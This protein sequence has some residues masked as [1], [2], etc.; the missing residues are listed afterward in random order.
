MKLTKLTKHMEFY[1]LEEDYEEIEQGFKA[2]KT[3]FREFLDAHEDFVGEENS[4]EHEQYLK[5]VESKYCSTVEAVKRVLKDRETELREAKLEEERIKKEAEAKDMS[6]GAEKEDTPSQVSEITRVL[7]YMQMPQRDLQTFDGDPM[8]YYPFISAFEAL[9]EREDID[10]RDKLLCLLHRCKGKALRAIQAFSMVENGYSKARAVLEERFGSTYRI[11]DTWLQHITDGPR[12]GASDH[13]GLRDFADDLR[14]CVETLAS[15]GA[16]AELNTLRVLRQITD[17]LPLFLRNRWRTHVQK[18]RR[19]VGQLG[20]PGIDELLDFVEDAAEEM[21][22][23]VYG[24]TATPKAK[25]GKFESFAVVNSTN[26]IACSGSCKNLFVCKAFKAMLVSDRYHFVREHRLC[27][28]CLSPDHMVSHCTSQKACSCG[29]KHVQLLHRGQF[30]RTKAQ[31]QSQA[32]VHA[33]PAQPPAA[34]QNADRGHEGASSGF[35]HVTSDRSTATLPVAMVQVRANGKVKT[36]NALLDTGSTVSFC[37]QSLVRDLSLAEVQ[38]SLNLTTM[39][40]RDQRIQSSFVKLEVS[41]KQG[42]DWHE[43]R[44]YTREFTEAGR[45]MP[46]CEFDHLL[47]LKFCTPGDVSLLIGQDYASLMMPMEVRTSGTSDEP[48]AVRTPLGWTLHGGHTGL[49]HVS[50]FMSIE[51]QLERFWRVED[52]SEVGENRSLND[53]KV[54]SLWDD[55]VCMENGHYQL[56]IPFK[57]DF[58]HFPLNV[59]MVEQRMDALKRKLLKND[60]LRVNYA[61]FMDDLFEK[62]YAEPATEADVKGRVWYLPHHSVNNPKKPDKTRVV[63]DCAA[64]FQS[65]SLNSRVLSGPDLNNS[66]IGVLFR[67]RMHP[68]AMAADIEAMFHQVRVKPMDRDFLRFLWW[69]GGDLTAHPQVYRMAVHLFGGTWS[70]SCCSYALRKTAI[71]NPEFGEEV[72]KLVLRNF[73]VD[74]CLFSVKDEEEALFMFSQLTTLLKKGGFNLTKWTSN[75]RE[76]LSK[77]PT[78]MRSKNLNKVEVTKELLPRE[79]VLGIEWSAESDAF[80]FCVQLQERPMTRRGLLSMIASLYDPLGFI[81][82]FTLCPKLLLQ[83]LCRLKFDWDQPLPP[84]VLCRWKDWVSQLPVL[85]EISVPRTLRNPGEVVRYQLHLFADASMRAYGAVCY[86]LVDYADG[87][88]SSSLVIA[89]S[90]LAPLHQMTVPRMEL[91]GAAL[92]VR[93][94]VSVRKEFDFPLEDSVFWTDSTIV[95]GYIKSDDKRYHTFVANRVSFIRRMTNAEQ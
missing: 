38:T 2:L 51:D 68:I 56:P 95:L 45:T 71:D 8:K 53:V 84:D 33:V 73:Y 65:M 88:R 10:T 58:P 46:S 17:R 57:E 94:E 11:A 92:A 83:D 42:Q 37:S 22:D 89:K 61:A 3:T 23:P 5:E 21:N 55:A 74:D 35:S 41:D 29:R 64:K 7:R 27:F 77:I 62:G 43:I 20:E 60:K 6:A 63:F 24:A 19:S 79:R 76:V 36:V 30:P 91:S 15:M 66:L 70:P 81:S 47:G 85:S 59:S 86:L 49:R 34:V 52:W 50:F 28:N 80:Q 13:Q 9:V 12:L 78:E 44:V 40:S 26:C 87:S 67:F 48:Y 69:P 54:L 39:S 16:L 72:K 93:L 90:R 82:P 14:S 31:N 25:G 4:D 1:I 32:D 18:K 75:S